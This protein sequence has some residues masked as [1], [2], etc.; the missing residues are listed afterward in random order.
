[1]RCDLNLEW[2]LTVRNSSG[3]SGT[4]MRVILEREAIMWTVDEIFVCD[5]ILNSGWD[6]TVR[7]G[8]ERRL[9]VVLELVFHHLVMHRR[10]RVVNI[11]YRL[12][13][14]KSKRE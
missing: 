9:Y 12:E 10:I 11:I 1:V 2:D 7:N 3:S 14:V 5:G 6:L 8:I 4:F 13:V